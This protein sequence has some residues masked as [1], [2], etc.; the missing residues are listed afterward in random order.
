MSLLENIHRPEDVRR[1]DADQLD[2]LAAELRQEI[3]EVCARNGGHLGA[4]IGTVEL[5]IALH[6]VFESPK[7]A[8]VFDVG[9]QAYVHKLLTGR[10]EAFQMLRK[11]DGVSGFLNRKESEHDWFGAGHAST[12]ISAS[13]GILEGK[14]VRG[15]PGRAVA[16]IGDGAMTGGMAFEGLFNAGAQTLDSGLIVVLNDNDMSIAPN[17]G[18]MSTWLSKKLTVGNTYLGLRQGIKDALKGIP[19]GERIKG[20]LKHAVEGTK[21]LLTPGIL[22]EGLGFAYMGPLDGHD[23]NA[24]EQAFAAAKNLQ[25]PVL[26]HVRTVKG[27]GYAPAERDRL[28]MHGVGAFEMDKKGEPVAKTGRGGPAKYQDVFAEALIREATRDDRIVGI[29]AAMPDGTS[30]GKFASAHPHRFY[31]VGIAEEHAVTFAAGLAA[32]G[33]KPV[34][35]IYSTFLQRALDQIIHDVALQELP[36]TFAMDRAGLVG[37]D[38][39]TH[40]GAFDIAYLRMIPNM[41]VMAPCNENELAG[42]LATAL[43]HDGPAAF[44]YPRGTGPGVAIESNPQAWPLGKGRWLRTT[45]APEVTILA[46]GT[47]SPIAV[48]AAETLEAEGILVDVADMRFAK[49]L[50]EELLLAAA[51]H[52]KLLVTLEEGCLAGGFGSAVLEHLNA[53]GLSTPVRRL[54]LPD[55]FVEHGDPVVQYARVGLDQEGIAAVCREVRRSAV[56]T[57]DSEQTEQ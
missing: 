49:P 7:D 22:F 27:K 4:S 25:E 37:A 19:Q 1:L 44:R 16:I 57:S 14:R 32:A 29:T 30:L 8:L 23:I 15:E 6:R 18:A 36:V 42:A 46:L 34:C 40:Q 41:V 20:M 50:D 31:D 48:K 12:S 39:A 45:E 51:Q 3:I 9:H 35:A 10:R 5:C 17:V 28:C 54:G 33:A 24:M 53:H 38:G 2:L 52:S 13:L 56:I 26:I 47:F 55:T 11:E 21:A 43:D